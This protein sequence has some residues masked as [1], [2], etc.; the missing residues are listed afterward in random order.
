MA[1]ASVESS[2]PA[3]PLGTSSGSEEAQSISCSCSSSALNDPGIREKAHRQSLQI[4]DCS[5]LGRLKIASED[6]CPQCGSTNVHGTNLNGVSEPIILYPLNIRA[7]RFEN[8]DLR[9]SDEKCE[10][11]KIPSFRG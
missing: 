3:G 11:Y 4:C 7:F 10:T 8:C 1:R 9:F 2:N 6:S 5:K